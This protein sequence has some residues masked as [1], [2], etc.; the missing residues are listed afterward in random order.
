MLSRCSD[1]LRNRLDTDDIESH[2]SENANRLRLRPTSH[3]QKPA[4]PADVD[5]AVQ[6]AQDHLEARGVVGPPS[7]ARLIP[8]ERSSS[9]VGS[10]LDQ[11][12]ISIERARIVAHSAPA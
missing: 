12:P 5:Q 9:H 6:T 11:P 3:D 7:D 2:L 10:P 8:L 1:E 4:L